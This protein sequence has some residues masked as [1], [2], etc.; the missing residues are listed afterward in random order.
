MKQRCVRGR[1]GVWHAVMHECVYAYVYV[2]VCVR[3]RVCTGIRVCVCVGGEDNAY[4]I[5]PSPLTSNLK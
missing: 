5:L 4:E 1:E 2:Y 3:A